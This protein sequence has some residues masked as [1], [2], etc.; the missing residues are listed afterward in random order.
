MRDPLRFVSG[1][2]A[3]VLLLFCSTLVAQDFAAETAEEKASREQFEQE[4]AAIKALSRPRDIFE[5]DFDPIAFDRVVVEDELGRGHVFF[6]LAFRI[7]NLVAEDEDVLAEKYSR[8]NQ[9]LDSIIQQYDGIEKDVAAGGRLRMEN[10]SA[11]RDQ[12]T[13]VIVKRPALKVKPRKISI[14]SL[15]IDEHGTRFRAL[16]PMPYTD[17][18]E[19]FDFEDHG[20]TAVNIPYMRVHDLVEEELRTRLFNT[21][22]IRRLE[23]PPYDPEQPS[24]FTNPDGELD[25]K[26]GFGMCQGEVKGVIIYPRLNPQAN[27]LTIRV[28]GLANNLRFDIPEKLP[29]LKVEDYFNMR[30]KRRTYVLEYERTGD[31]FYR[32]RDAFDLV[33]QGY[34]WV[35]SFQRLH[36]RRDYALS[37]Y[38]LNNIRLREETTEQVEVT[39]P[40]VDGQDQVTVEVP[41]ILN[42]QV[43]D[44][45]LDY[46][47]QQQREVPEEYA[48]KL[49]ALDAEMAALAERYDDPESDYRQD[50]KKAW[51][52]LL[53]KQRSLIEETRA[54]LDWSLRKT[55]SNQWLIEGNQ[56]Q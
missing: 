5:F 1:S 26:D 22:E 3:C 31:E 53:E 16:D 35:S 39:F 32:G 12:E 8:Y 28:H 47:R 40:V 52:S 9:V 44:E 4:L 30:I 42:D 41:K 17:D 51:Q 24:T 21:D 10:A 49:E 48:A 34:R 55:I 19:A 38:F 36:R 27:H 18:P 6:Y 23:I 7:R 43:R 15:V 29:R 37:R 33:R 50:Q 45:L 13:G 56:Y 2:L 20:A 11:L 54:A 46:Y 25:Q 14:T